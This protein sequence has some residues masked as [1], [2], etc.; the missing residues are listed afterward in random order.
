M[1]RKNKNETDHA[2]QGF[3]YP[4]L[5]GK[6]FRG[7]KTLEDNERDKIENWGRAVE[8]KEKMIYEL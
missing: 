2:N 5:H 7:M 8:V 3:G 6:K 1:R 4:S